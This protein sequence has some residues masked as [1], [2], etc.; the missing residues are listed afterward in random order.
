MGYLLRD[1]DLQTYRLR[2][3]TSGSS[4][5]QLLHRVVPTFRR[6]DTL[7][8]TRNQGD[9]EFASFQPS[10]IRTEGFIQNQMALTTKIR[11]GLASTQTGCCTV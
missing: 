3:S 5:A 7:T 10:N 8:V 4:I 6:A 1:L 2:I 11:L 9:G